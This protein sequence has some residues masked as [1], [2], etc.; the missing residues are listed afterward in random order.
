[1]TENTPFPGLGVNWATFESEQGEISIKDIY[2]AHS[3][4]LGLDSFQNVDIKLST[5]CFESYT[6]WLKEQDVV[7]GCMY[8]MWDEDIM[9]ILKT[10]YAISIV[11]NGSKYIRKYSKKYEGIRGIGSVI[12]DR[13]RGYVRKYPPSI[14]EMLELQDLA[15]SSEELQELGEKVPSSEAVRKEVEAFVDNK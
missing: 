4:T 11:V 3:K 2:A 15:A 5:D 14:D 1:M 7:I 6:D 13:F 9:N 8:N 10:K 12:E